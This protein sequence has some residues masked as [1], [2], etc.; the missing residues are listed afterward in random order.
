VQFVSV[1]EASSGVGDI[2]PW[3]EPV[4]TATILAEV[5][6]QIRR[7]TILHDDA[8]AVAITLFVPFA[9]VHNEIAVYSPMLAIISAEADSGKTTLCGTL[10]LLTP[11]AR[12]AAEL[13][14]ASLF[15]YV[16][17]Y[18]PTLFIDDADRLFKRKPDLVHVV[19]VG[20]TRDEAMIP[21]TGPKGDVHWYSVFCCKIIA[22]VDLQMAKETR[23][24]CIF[25]K[26]LPKLRSEKV[27]AFKHVVQRWL[28]ADPT[29]EWADFRGRGPIS[30]RQIALLLDAYDIHP[31][32]IHPR[33][34]S[35]DRGYRV[36]WFEL[37]FRHHLDKSPPCKRA[38][39]RKPAK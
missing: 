20:R 21:R 34:R 35:S 1:E 19:N 9:W 18:H 27:D 17:F 30:Q 26:M 3:P 14:A 16:D 24:R 25:V 6:A 32:F 5:M 23:T 8:A 33:G 7:Y 10:R 36:E 22:G 4:S 37:A 11:R 13:T 31:D 38:T 28:T 12:G 2:E 29:G 39:V 15:R